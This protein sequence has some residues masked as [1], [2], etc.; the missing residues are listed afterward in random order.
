MP[1]LRAAKRYAKALFDAASKA[2]M[3]DS[4]CDDFATIVA[5]LEK[6]EKF[7]EV[8]L[9]PEV[10]R[11]DKIKL[12][13]SLF[14]DRVTAITLAM[15]R[16][17]LT[18]GREAELTAIQSEL[19]GMRKTDQHMVSVRIESAFELSA[20]EKQML[21]RK[22]EELSGR[23]AD[24]AFFTN[25]SLIGGVL[26][27]FETVIYDGTLKGQLQRLKDQLTADSSTQTN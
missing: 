23:R 24:A 21:V 12:I 17:I 18:K 25:S 20:E 13:E 19:E 11:E 8:M 16:L 3:V 5:I 14:D 26:I 15:L 7:N 9:S 27:Q 6:H 22:A 10:Q 2:S 1:D 4:V